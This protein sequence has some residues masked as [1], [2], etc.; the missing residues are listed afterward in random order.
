MTKPKLQQLKVIVHEILKEDERTRNSDSLLYFK[1][2]ERVA[3]AS[4]C[5]VSPLTMTVAY[6]L[7]HMNEHGFPPFESVRRARQ[8]AQAECPELKACE[9]VQAM[10]FANEEEYKRFALT[11]DKRNLAIP[12]RCVNTG[13]IFASA[14]DAA[15]AYGLHRSYVAGLCN[16]HK[17]PKETSLRFEYYSAIYSND[18]H[19]GASICWHCANAYGGCE[20]TGRDDRGQ[21]KFEPVPGWE[22]VKTTVSI[23]GGRRETSYKVI[24]CP[25]YVPEKGGKHG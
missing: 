23:G 24:A 13:E 9:K 15:E 5:P 17:R 1:V 22:A 14:A 10:R 25:K 18:I 21:I 12:V 19:G 8:K 2:L 20:W 6:F 3:K 4:D 16:G 7:H 11:Q